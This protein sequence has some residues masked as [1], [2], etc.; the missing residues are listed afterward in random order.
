MLEQ[1]TAEDLAHALLK[2][3]NCPITQ[4]GHNTATPAEQ[5]QSLKNYLDW[6]NRTALPVLTRYY[7]TLDKVGRALDQFR[8]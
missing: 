8:S 2:A 5:R 6:W 7:G 3:W 1:A 4:S